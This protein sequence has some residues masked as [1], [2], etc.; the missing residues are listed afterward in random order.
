MEG[1]NCVGERMGKRVWWVFQMYGKPGREPG[2]Q[3][4][5][6]RGCTSLGCGKNQRPGMGKIKRVY[7]SDYS[8][9]S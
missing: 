3:R 4:K 5:I 2:K 1:E 6:G 9:D 8:R 7:K